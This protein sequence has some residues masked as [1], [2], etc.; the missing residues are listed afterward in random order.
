ML[1]HRQVVVAYPHRRTGLTIFSQVI[2]YNDEGA[3]LGI[4]HCSYDQGRILVVNES[5]IDSYGNIRQIAHLGAKGDNVAAAYNSVERF[6]DGTVVWTITQDRVTGSAA[7]RPDG[8]IVFVQGQMNAAAKLAAQNLG[9]EDVMNDE[10]V[11]GFSLYACKP[12]EEPMQIAFKNKVND[13][14]NY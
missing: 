13:R 11:P 9:A 5:G 7:L 6:D 8:E 10:W 2:Q 1:K 4:K 14:S 3:V 12:T